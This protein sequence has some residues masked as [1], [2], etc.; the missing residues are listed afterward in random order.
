MKSYKTE[1]SQKELL[2]IDSGVALPAIVRISEQSDHLSFYTGPD[3]VY[4]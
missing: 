4:K 2:S 1:A 3:I